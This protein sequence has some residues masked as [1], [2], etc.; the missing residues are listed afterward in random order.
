MSYEELRLMNRLFYNLIEQNPSV[1]VKDIRK[2]ERV[3][4]TLFINEPFG[5]RTTMSPK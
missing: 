3:G 4:E 1:Q 2:N 5:D